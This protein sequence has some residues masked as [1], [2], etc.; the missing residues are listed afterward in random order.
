MNNSRKKIN[1]NLVLLL[2][3]RGV[4]DMGASIQMIVMPLYII[5]MGGSA[6]TVGLY[7]F[8]SLATVLAYPPAGVL[9]DRF[10]RKF[11]MVVTDFASAGV[12]LLLFICS[13]FHWVN[14]SILLI[15]QVLIA[16]LNGLFDP[17]TK[18]M[19]PQIVE[20]SQLTKVN[21]GISALRTIFVLMGS[22]IGSMLYAGV[23]VTVLF[24]LNGISF[25]LSACSEMLI[26][27]HHVRSDKNGNSTG[28]LR[29]LMDGIRF[30][31][32]NK[33][34]GK[35]C[36]YFFATFALI[37]P[38]FNVVMPVFFRGSLRY[39]DMQYGYLQMVIIVGALFGSIIVGALFG[40]S[41]QLRKSLTIGCSLMTGVLVLFTVLLF[42]FC[43][44]LF[45]NDTLTF[46]LL[47][48]AVLCLLSAV[49]MLIHIPVQTYIQIAT[50]NEYMSRI[51]SIVGMIT[52]GGMP[53]G[54]LIY[55]LILEKM[56]VHWTMLFTTLMTI[57]ISFLFLI[58]LSKMQ[59]KDK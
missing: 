49:L 56:E 55:G 18:G 43:I 22:A 6:A 39:S 58:S 25:L 19:V 52:K 21:S 44:Q 10:N 33:V 48:A 26:S 15:A 13:Y 24:F 47:L 12:V 37:Q 34:I 2:L 17:A 41:V 35:L 42:P 32:N 30:I 4:S 29:D 8:L 36:V 14:L 38:I 53:L 3:G 40:K 20:Q 7:S 45:G 1:K 23:G 28:L 50:P 9:G 5:D 31:L 11:I 27:Y 54:G 57:L 59:L 46:F 16:A 51:F